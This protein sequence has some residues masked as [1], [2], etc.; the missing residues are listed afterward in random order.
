MEYHKL[1]GQDK[2]DKEQQK[3]KKRWS[4]WRKKEV[5]KKK[6]EKAEEKKRTS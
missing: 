3:L 4:H 2:L 5:E 6:L 1:K